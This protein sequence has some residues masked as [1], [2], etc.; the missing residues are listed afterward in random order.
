[1]S[2]AIH[3][4]IDHAAQQ[5]SRIDELTGALERLGAHLE[6]LDG[7]DVSIAD[8]RKLGEVIQNK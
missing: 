2:L 1:M 5:S 7:C 6:Q 3:G 8:L 4:L